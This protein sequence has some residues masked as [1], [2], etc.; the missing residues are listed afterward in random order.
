[1]KSTRKSG[2]AGR[3]EKVAGR[4]ALA[5]ACLMTPVLP[6]FAQASLSA[7]SQTMSITLTGQSMI[8]TDI[9]AH[10]P[11]A[12]PVI[13]S[14]LKGDVI[15]TNFETTIFDPRKG[16][17]RTDG[18]F[19]SQPEAMEALKTFGF[20]LLSLANNHSFDL[21]T[22]GVQNVLEQSTRLN[23]AHAGVGKT[24]DEAVAPGYLKTPK[25]TVALIA[26]A[27]GL[28]PDGG[29]A[30]ASRAGV[31]ELHVAGDEPSGEDTRRILQSIGEARKKADL[32]IV[33]EHNHIF[34]KPFQTIMLEELP[35]RLGPPEWLKKWTHAEIDAGMH[36]APL[37]HAVEIYHGHPIFFDHGNFIFQ[38]PPQDTL[39]D[40]PILWESV[41][42]Y[43]EFQGRNLQSIKFRPIAQ[44]KIGE[45]QPDV[46][47]EHTDNLFLQTRGLP[48]LA[49][50][51][52]AHYILERL[53]DLSR[54]FGTTVVVNG[55]MAE[56]KLKSGK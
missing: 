42:A 23:V 10:S 9:R 44:N 45:G 55:D 36:G 2:L 1:M 25:G 29:N 28:V 12:V 16:Q 19:V 43:V 18:R 30:T 26:M 46:H 51:E 56:I 6:L 27:S 11:A 50:G 7:Q 37:L 31:N 34:A 24:I 32:V 41:V 5:T 52:Q 35:E 54:P 48:K 17:K 21:K 49:T 13:Q 33:Y 22:A 8:R 38:V 40:E 20:N 15:F 3:R 53:A 14:L 39:L 4:L 47:E